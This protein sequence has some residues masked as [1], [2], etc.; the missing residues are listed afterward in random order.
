VG[1]TFFFFFGFRGAAIPG[2][3]MNQAEAVGEHGGTLRAVQQEDG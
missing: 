3:L 2:R 1:M